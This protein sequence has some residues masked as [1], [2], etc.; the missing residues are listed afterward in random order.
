[1]LGE[2][3]D[4]VQALL[5]VVVGFSPLS[6]AT[7]PEEVTT[8]AAAAAGP[9]IQ[10]E[11]G[12][13]IQWA[14]GSIGEIVEFGIGSTGDLVQFGIGSTGDALQW[15]ITRVIQEAEPEIMA[16]ARRVQEGFVVS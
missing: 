11:P 10:S 16:S 8:L 4:L 13:A 7:A 6:V 1:V 3:G 9:Q 12:D 14:L 5:N 2:V 15:A